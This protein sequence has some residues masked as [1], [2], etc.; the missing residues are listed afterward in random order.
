M[1]FGWS[2]CGAEK[3]T[4][5][6]LKRFTDWDGREAWWQ[7]RLGLNGNVQPTYRGVKAV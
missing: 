4:R 1:A 2:E 6:V 3:M 7:E 5:I